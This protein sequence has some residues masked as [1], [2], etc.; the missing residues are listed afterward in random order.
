[1][2]DFV[3]SVFKT[4]ESSVT[5]GLVEAGIVYAI[6]ASALPS[7]A[8]IRSAPPHNK[9]IEAVRKAAAYKSAVM[10]ALVFML[11]RDINST[12]IGSAALAGVDYWVK[13]SNGMDPQTGKLAGAGAGK[14]VPNDIAFPM[15]D[16]A[17]ADPADPTEMLDY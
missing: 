8:D 13:H 15:P 7:H 5:T 2:A 4:P 11:T 12:L 6:Y 17:D 3:K 10:L 14:P 1:M 9:D 16:Y